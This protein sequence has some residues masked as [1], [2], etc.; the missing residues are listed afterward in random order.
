MCDAS[1]GTDDS[2]CDSVARHVAPYVALIAVDHDRE[3]NFVVC[4]VE[5][6]AVRV[7]GEHDIDAGLVEDR[8]EQIPE[9]VA[10]VPRS[11]V[12]RNMEEDDACRGVAE[13]FGGH[14][15]AE[16]FALFAAIGVVVGK[17]SVFD[18]RVRLVFAAVEQQETDR[19]DFA[20]LVVTAVARREIVVQTVGEDAA[21]L[22]VAAVVEYRGLRGVK[23][24][25][26]VDEIRNNCSSFSMLLDMSPLSITKSCLPKLISRHSSVMSSARPWM[27]FRMTNEQS[28][29]VAGNVRNRNGA[30]L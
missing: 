10:A 20:E 9:V 2:D 23:V 8:Q 13:G 7:A 27:S 21:R 22:M 3:P 26:G 12:E 5:A 15:P 17:P 30:R 4:R 29:P 24:Y 6:V 14:R 25:R 16:P 28:V 1:A 18:V 19:S 11:A